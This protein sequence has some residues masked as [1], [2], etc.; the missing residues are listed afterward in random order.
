M[1]GLYIDPLGSIVAVVFLAVAVFWI[2][3]RSYKR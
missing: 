3:G 1:P 2:L